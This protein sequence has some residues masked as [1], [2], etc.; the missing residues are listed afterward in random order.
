M[1]KDDYEEFKIE[2]YMTQPDPEVPNIPQRIILQMILNCLADA[3]E[4]EL[5]VAVIKFLKMSSLSLR[6]YM[7]STG[8]WD[9]YLDGPP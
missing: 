6:R 4:E 7:K 2:D 8:S 1:N 9:K 3:S 5:N